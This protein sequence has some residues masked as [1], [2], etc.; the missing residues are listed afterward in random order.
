MAQVAKETAGFFR[1][2]HRAFTD[3]PTD[4]DEWP[5]R[6]TIRGVIQAYLEKAKAL[7]EGEEE[8]RYVEA[9]H[10]GFAAGP[11]TRLQVRSSVTYIA[12]AI[13][14][15]H[16][17]G[18]P[19]FGD[20]GPFS[21]VQPGYAAQRAAGQLRQLETNHQE[22]SRDRLPVAAIDCEHVRAY[23]I[24]VGE[25][26]EASH[27]LMPLVIELNHAAGLELN[28]ATVNRVELSSGLLQEDAGLIAQGLEDQFDLPPWLGSATYSLRHSA[29]MR[30]TGRCE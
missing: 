6:D 16:L 4:D 23:M 26:F 2:L 8:L 12:Q 30:V 29:S 27:P 19:L 11:V 25:L 22:P 21:R 17:P 13:N 9:L 1:Q 7:L 28:P 10:L 15:V 5:L 14:D 24:R 20:V 18:Q 3:R